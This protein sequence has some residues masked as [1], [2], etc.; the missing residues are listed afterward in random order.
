M[1]AFF[2]LR[3][4]PGVDVDARRA[5]LCAAL[6]RQGFRPPRRVDLPEG[7]IHLY[8]TLASGAPVAMVESPDGVGLATGTF[9]YRGAAGSDALRRFLADFVW[10]DVPWDEV[11]GQFCLLVRTRGRLHLLTD[12]LGLYKV[13][14]NADASVLSSSFLALTAATPRRTIDPQHVYEYVFQGATFGRGTVFR[15]I[16]ILDPD[17]VHTVASSGVSARALPRLPHGW[18][19]A[20]PDTLLEQ[21]LTA[22]RRTVATIAA[23]A[24]HGVSSA[25]T[26]GYDSRLL[27]ALLRERGMRPHLYVYG[28]ADDCDVRIAQRIAT[29]EGLA[30]AHT[31]RRAAPPLPPDALAAAVATNYQVFDGYPVDGIVDDGADLATRRAR[32]RHGEWMLNGIGGEL[33]RR[34]DLPNRAHDVREVVWRFY[35]GFDPGDCTGA[36]DEEAYYAAVGQA[37]RHALGAESEPLARSLVALAVPAFYYRYWAGRNCSVNNRLGHAL[38]PFCDLPIVREAVR[39]PVRARAYGAFE[40][41][42]IRAVDPRLARY[43]SCHGHAFTQPLP[44][45]AMVREWRATVRPAVY[46]RYGVAPRGG[47]RPH[48][49]EPAA[50]AALID[51]TFPYLRRFFHLE[52]RFSALRVNRICTLEYLFERCHADVP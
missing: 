40:T 34:P 33:Y 36:F 51:P 27:L 20:D 43:D 14:R 1:G 9:L 16:E 15:E 30:L 13:Y 31:D 45:P 42:L 4:A 47:A 18:N 29:G 19:T 49:L 39:I 17:A 22:L 25:L 23:A 50:I 35:C 12:R 11:C 21:N 26:G 3:H 41:A 48:W 2:L 7:E 24:P 10:P 52:R 8:P 6:E 32:C 28:G 38:Q 37:L 46:A 5:V 44:L